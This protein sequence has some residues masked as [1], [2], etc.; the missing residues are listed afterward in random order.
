M[1]PEGVT[2]LGG[3]TDTECGEGMDAEYLVTGGIP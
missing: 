1:W 3:H 2:T